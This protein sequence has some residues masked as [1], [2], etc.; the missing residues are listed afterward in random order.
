MKLTS[1]VPTINSLES[2]I[3]SFP[4][5]AFSLLVDS[6]TSLQINWLEGNIEAVSGYK[7][8]EILKWKLADAMACINDAH[9]SFVYQAVRN[10]LKFDRY[11][12]VKFKLRCADKSE[13]WVWVKMKSERINSG[14]ILCEGFLTDISDLHEKDRKLVF[15]KELNVEAEKI[16]FLKNLSHEIRT[17]LNSI[18]G[19]TS[20]LDKSPGQQSDYIK[21]IKQSCSQ[22]TNT[23]N[24]ILEL[25]ELELCGV[26]NDKHEFNLNDL[27]DD[28]FEMFSDRFQHKNISLFPL[29]TKANED[30]VLFSD[31]IKV[32]KILTKLLDNALK[33]TNHGKVELGYELRP[34]TAIVYVLDS[35]IGIP[36]DKKDKIFKKF[37]QISH[38]DRVVQG[39]GLGLSI[40]DALIESLN[41]EIHVNSIV[42]VGSQ[43][44]I[45]IP[46]Y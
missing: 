35:G 14:E 22:L 3:A 2:F 25:S 11:Q 44:T 41:G 15:E 36:L 38:R 10:G 43:F 30:T 17:P 29:K 26:Q 27:F 46:R 5:T 12:S 9:M 8:N 18:V 16:D 24:D 7:V 6:K 33:Y 42:G 37:Y 45:E 40:A 20:L 31:E 23:V 21:I 34:D 39:L 1:K 13:L 19:F 32:L 28:L 4:G